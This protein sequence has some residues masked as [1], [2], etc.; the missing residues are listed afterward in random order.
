MSSLLNPVGPEPASVYWRRRIIAIVAVI[1]VIAV[2]LWIVGKIFG[3]GSDN[4]SSA[5]PTPLPTLAT[6]SPTPSGSSAPSGAPCLDTD[7][8]VTVAAEQGAYPVGGPVEFVMKIA[9]TGA[10]A[11][12]RDVGPAAN[13]FTVTSGGFD[14]WTSDACSPAGDSQEEEIPPGEAFAVKGTWDATVTADGC[15]ASASAA[16]AGAY[17]VKASNGTVSSDEVTFALG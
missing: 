14:V 8:E 3:G 17:E 6:G 7:I 5:G 9:N 16:Q 1:A 15:G 2:F 13:T 11:C 10:V 12:V 4:N